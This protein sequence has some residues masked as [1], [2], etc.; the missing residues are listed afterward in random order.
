M[1][2]EKKQFNVYFQMQKKSRECI[3]QQLR[4]IKKLSMEAILTFVAINWK[5]IA[6]WTWNVQKW[7]NKETSESSKT[8]Y[9]RQV[10]GKINKRFLE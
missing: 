7:P 10:N 1:R 5:K 3:G 9:I 2:N 8:D 6:T 4:G